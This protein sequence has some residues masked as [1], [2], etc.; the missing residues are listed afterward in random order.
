MK[1]NSLRKALPLS[2]LLLGLAGNADAAIYTFTT[3]NT[4]FATL[5]VSQVDA[6]NNYTFA[7]SFLNNANG[8]F[9]NGN[10]IDSL[11]VDNANNLDPTGTSSFSAGPTAGSVTNPTTNFLSRTSRTPNYDFEYRFIL[12]GGGSFNIRDSASWIAAFNSSPGIFSKFSLR[13][14]NGSGTVTR[15]ESVAAASAVSEPETYAM[16]LAGLGLLGFASRRKQA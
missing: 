1:F 8:T 15:V 12:G 6:T 13:I 10:Y 5:S 2:M 14:D 4:N 7:L 9:Q 16:F 3:N 11:A